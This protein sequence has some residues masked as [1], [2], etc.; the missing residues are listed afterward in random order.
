MVDRLGAVRESTAWVC[1]GA[2]HVS[3]NAEALK[4]LAG[5]MA[6]DHKLQLEGASGGEQGGV[7]WGEAIHYSGSEATMVQYLFVLDALNFCFWPSEGKW[8]YEDLS[9]A[10][11]RAVEADAAALSAESLA[12]MTEETLCGLLGGRALPNMPARV[13]HIRQVGA[14]LLE[15]WSGSAADMVR[16]CNGSAGR[17]VDLIVTSF[18][19]YVCIMMYVCMH[20]CTSMHAFMY[21][22]IHAYIH[23]YIHRYAYNALYVP[24]CNAYVLHIAQFFLKGMRIHTRAYMHTHKTCTRTHHTHTHTQV[25]R[26]SGIQ[27]AASL[28]LQACADSRRRYL[29]R[30]QGEGARRHA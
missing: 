23:T 28:L 24:A 15:H 16:A 7:G 22:C 29:G 12:K 30:V 13:E 11:K 27:G 10:L 21:A 14:G 17:L 2:R 9:T 26:P 5:E 3:L 1:K 18:P 20:A 8:E 6:K 25:S 4:A 19:G